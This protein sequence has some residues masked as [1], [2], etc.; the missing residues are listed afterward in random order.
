MSSY[1]IIILP[2]FCML[3]LYINETSR[4]NPGANIYQIKQIL[5]SLDY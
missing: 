1:H 2:I 3:I 4:I 5:Y